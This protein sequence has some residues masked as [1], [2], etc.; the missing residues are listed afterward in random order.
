MK[1]ALAVFA[2]L[3]LSSP[4]F[5][6]TNPC[7]TSAGTTVIV[8]PKNI[9][10]QLPDQNATVL[11]STSPAVVSYTLG[12]FAQGVDPNTGAP[13][14]S[15]TLDRTKFTLVAGT[16]DCY[17][18]DATAAGTVL[19]S[20]PVGAVFVAA[21]RANGDPTIGNSAWGAVSSPFGKPAALRAP[22]AV[23]HP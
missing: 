5:A 14:Q 6:Q 2:F 13:V 1:A 20:Y 17:Q 9:A 15:Q 16:T 3:L 11:G 12:Y 23:I 7:S 18:Y 4:A 10:A 22:K 21:L 8:A 19:S